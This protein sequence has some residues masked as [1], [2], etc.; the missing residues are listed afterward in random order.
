MT[1]FVVGKSN[2]A[3]KS[4]DQ[5]EGGSLAGVDVLATKQRIVEAGRDVLY[6]VVVRNADANY[7]STV[8]VVGD[9]F[10]VSNCL[11]WH[12]GGIMRV[13]GLVILISCVFAQGCYSSVR[14]YDR[15]EN[16]IGECRDAMM[17][18]GA[19]PFPK[20][21]GGCRGSANP[22]EQSANETLRPL[23]QEKSKEPRCPE[24]QEVRGF[25]FGAECYPIN[26]L[27]RRREA[28]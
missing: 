6:A 2:G 9:D 25:G 10:A 19:V 28:K 17:L 8:V 24:G 7:C 12:D 13:I 18:L 21:W 11:T 26:P 23:P 3:G 4:L 16:L 15:E 14:T 22:L 5:D 27:I 1:L 20:P